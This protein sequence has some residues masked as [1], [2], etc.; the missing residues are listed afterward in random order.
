MQ[1]VETKAK[2]DGYTAIRLDAFS[3]NPKSLE[4]YQGL[5]YSLAGQ[6]YFRKGMFYCFEKVI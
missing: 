5:G 2:N 4:L 3:A 1:F 6:V